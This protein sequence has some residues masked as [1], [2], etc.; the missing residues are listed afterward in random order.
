MSQHMN[1]THANIFT[2]VIFKIHQG[3]SRWKGNLFTFLDESA[4]IT[5]VSY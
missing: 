3:L 1:F 2:R 4:S 5:L